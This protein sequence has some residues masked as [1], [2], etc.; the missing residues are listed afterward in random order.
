MKIYLCIFLE[1]K[2]LSGVKNILDFPPK[3]SFLDRL[4][5]LSN[6]TQLQNELDAFQFSSG[7]HLNCISQL[8]LLLYVKSRKCHKLSQCCLFKM[9]LVLMSVTFIELKSSTSKSIIFS[10][11]KCVVIVMSPEKLL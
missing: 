6:F 11:R 5:V 9:D 10:P 3:V 2:S 4:D 1:T 7:M 8:S